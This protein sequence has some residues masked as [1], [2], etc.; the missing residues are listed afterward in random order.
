MKFIVPVIVWILLS[1]LAAL[2]GIKLANMFEIQPTPQ[3][4]GKIFFLWPI[5]LVVFLAGFISAIVGGIILGMHGID[6][7][8]GIH[9]E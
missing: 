4:I 9:S 8:R 7:E 5:L 3:M 2:G 1:Y 6:I